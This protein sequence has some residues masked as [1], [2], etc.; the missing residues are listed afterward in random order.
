[1]RLHK[2]RSWNEV[3]NCFYYFKN[4]TYYNRDNYSILNFTLHHLFNWNNAEQYTGLLDMNKIEIHEG[5]KLFGREEGDGETTAWT[6][7][8]Y[9][10]FYDATSGAFKVKDKHTEENSSWCSYIDEV[11]DEYE[12]IGHIHETI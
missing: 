12:V 9:T 5:D 10:V 2:F 7:M 3:D 4:G 6:N 1:M 11:N 8:Y